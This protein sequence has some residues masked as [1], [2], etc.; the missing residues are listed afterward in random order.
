MNAMDA[1]E[2]INLQNLQ[3]MYACAA[4]S[5]AELRNICYSWLLGKMSVGKIWVA[6]I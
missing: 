2:T 4:A 3:Y 5:S 1:K 6:F